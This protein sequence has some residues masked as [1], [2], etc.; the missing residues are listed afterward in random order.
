[1]EKIV[2]RAPLRQEDKIFYMAGLERA[3]VPRECAVVGAAKGTG[4]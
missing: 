3:G 1:V 2:S 4:S